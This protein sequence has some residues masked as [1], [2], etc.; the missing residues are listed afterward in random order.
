[1]T[2]EPQEVRRA[3]AALPAIYDANGQVLWTE[4]QLI[5][6]IRR[7]WPYRYCD[8]ARQA[9]RWRTAELRFLR[10]GYYCKI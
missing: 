1:M 3:I 9:I 2:F 6:S 5:Q 4:P 10:T 8:E 7:N